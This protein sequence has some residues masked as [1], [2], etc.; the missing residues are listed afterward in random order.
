VR[1][2][3]IRQFGVGGED[4]CDCRCFV[5]VLETVLAGIKRGLSLEIGQ[6]VVCLVQRQ[7]F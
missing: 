2:S 1:E 6:G 4:A 5:L 3:T 7:T